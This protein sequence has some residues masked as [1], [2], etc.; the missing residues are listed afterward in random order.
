MADA[1]TM[2]NVPFLWE[3]TDRKGNKI[4]GKSLAANEEAVRADLTTPRGSAEQDPQ[5]EARASSRHLLK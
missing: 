2:G 3:G 4:K 5:A 1:A